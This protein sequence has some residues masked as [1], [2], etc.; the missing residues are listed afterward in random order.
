MTL[1]RFFFSLTVTFT[2]LFLVACGA[3]PSQDS[4]DN[5]ICMAESFA[6]D[7]KYNEEILEWNKLEK[8]N[9]KNP[10]LY[11]KRGFAYYLNEQYKEAV[12]DFTRELSASNSNEI[13]RMRGAAYSAMGEYDQ[14]LA[15]FNAVLITNPK[16]FETQGYRGITYAQE[17]KLQEALKD[18]SACLA[19]RPSALTN[20]NIAAVYSKMGKYDDALK[21]YSDTINNASDTLDESFFARAAQIGRGI[22]YMKKGAYENGIRE[23]SKYLDIDSENIHPDSDLGRLIRH[24]NGR[25]RYNRS[26]AYEKLGKTKLAEEDKRVAEELGYKPGKQ[27]PDFYLEFVDE[28]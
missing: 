26:I 28:Q 3:G 4:Q 19:A 16:D 2:S 20:N 9:P 18:L 22:V 17:G 12:A 25:A 5:L 7:R 6:I 1:A 14:A 11:R 27:M 8:L 10:E 23:F 24:M 21:I 15:D 13:R